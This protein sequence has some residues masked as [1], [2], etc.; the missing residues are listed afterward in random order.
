MYYIKSTARAYNPNS[1]VKHLI[2]SM[3]ILQATLPPTP[4]FLSQWNAI[5]RVNHQVVLYPV[6]IISKSMI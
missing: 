5:Y 1:S 4:T 3:D 2:V 6:S